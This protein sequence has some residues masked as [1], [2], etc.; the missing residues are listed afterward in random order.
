MDTN[1]RHQHDM[2]K[3]KYNKPIITF[4]ALD[5][6]VD[7]IADNMDMEK[8]KEMLKQEYPEGFDVENNDHD[9]PLPPGWTRIMNTT[10]KK[11]FYSNT[12]LGKN[13]IYCSLMYLIT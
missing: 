7:R 13:Q 5:A 12:N 6:M 1:D 11:Y 3:I 8:L 2:K 10:T 9:H 4:N